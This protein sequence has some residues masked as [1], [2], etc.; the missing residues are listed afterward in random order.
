MVKFS[1][2]L[3]SL[4]FLNKLNAIQSML[5]LKIESIEEKIGEM[6]FYNRRHGESMSNSQSIKKRRISP[7]D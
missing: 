7:C 2:L 1:K 4:R 6:T 5:E 3:T